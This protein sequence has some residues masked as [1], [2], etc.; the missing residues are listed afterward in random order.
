MKAQVQA[1][2]GIGRCMKQLEGN[3]ICVYIKGFLG[4][5]CGSGYLRHTEKKA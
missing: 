4:V 3:P 1:H 2:L 5:G